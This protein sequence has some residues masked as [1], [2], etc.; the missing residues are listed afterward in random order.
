MKKNIII[1]VILFLLFG[2]LFQYYISQTQNKRFIN[3]I[4]EVKQATE[5]KN[6]RCQFD[7]FEL[8]NDIQSYLRNDGLELFSNITVYDLETNEAIRLQDLLSHKTLLVRISQAN[9]MACLDAILPLLDKVN[10]EQVILLADYTNKH[11]LKKIKENHQIKYS[12]YRIKSI[13]PIPVEELDVP[14]M[15]IADR[16]MQIECLYVPHKEMLDEVEM[17]IDILK[18]RLS[19]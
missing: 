3:V 10:K 9:C 13:L 4:T 8:K 1:G 7:L 5:Q 14:Y 18:N 2:N 19:I 6:N 15:F 16:N 12:C 17:C 11:F